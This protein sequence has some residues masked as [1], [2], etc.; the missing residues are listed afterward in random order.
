MICGAVS[1]GLL[2]KVAP[3]LVTV[4]IMGTSPAPAKDAGSLKLIRSHPGIA[5][6]GMTATIESPVM[7]VVPTVTFTSL[8][9]ALLTPVKLTSSTVGT[10]AP[11]MSV[12]VVVRFRASRLSQSAAQHVANGEDGEV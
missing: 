7:S 6:F 12:V 9:T 4:T 3:A 1:A 8:I 11:D 10:T 5:G 2:E